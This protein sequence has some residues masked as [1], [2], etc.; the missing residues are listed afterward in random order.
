[1]PD[2]VLEREEGLF[3]FEPALKRMRKA[4]Q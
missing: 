1:V 3:V 4:A 2:R